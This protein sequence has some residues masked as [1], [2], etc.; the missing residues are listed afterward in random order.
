MFDV[1][2]R[3][4]GDAQDSTSGATVLTG[5]T[6]SVR[7]IGFDSSGNALV[8]GSHDNTLRLWSTQ[9][10]EEIKTLRGHGSRVESVA[11]SPD[12]R[13]AVS[14]SQDGRVRVWDVAGYA[15]SRVLGS[16][17]LAGHADA[18]L[19]ARFTP[20]GRVLTASRDRTAQL[21]DPNTAESLALFAAG[22]EFLASSAEFFDNGRRLV[23]GAGDNSARVWDVG[24]GAAVAGLS[25]HRP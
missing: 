15:E 18:V 24:S 11:F 12:G 17:T 19:A 10:G 22:H 7:S 13:L 6:G 21:W 25:E 20:D 8:S 5:H 16:R 1:A 2:S 4:A 14:G 9:S 23:T 3:L